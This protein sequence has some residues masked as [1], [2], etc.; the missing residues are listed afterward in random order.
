ME[1]IVNDIL[2]DSNPPPLENLAAM[3]EATFQLLQEKPSPIPV[4]EP[5][6]SSSRKRPLSSRH[7]NSSRH[8]SPTLSE[9][10][11][12][13]NDEKESLKRWENRLYNFK[14]ELEQKERR[15]QKESCDFLHLLDTRDSRCWR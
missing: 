3:C 15:L 10:W 14:D 1:S 7:S 12:R 2:T 6:A 4:N 8:S 9:E 11:E 13:L 5:P